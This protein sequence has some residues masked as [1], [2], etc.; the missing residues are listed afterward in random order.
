[1]THL[2][3]LILSLSLSPVYHHLTPY[4]S[5]TP[6][7]L[8]LPPISPITSIF[9]HH[10]IHSLQFQHPVLAEPTHNQIWTPVFPFIPNRHHLCP[11]ALA[12]YIRRRGQARS[13]S[14]LQ[15]SR[16]ATQQAL[17]LL[18]PR[19]DLPILKLQEWPLQPPPHQVL[20]PSWTLSYLVLRN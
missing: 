5:L 16:R 14:S 6:S 10:L 1:M 13:I 19:R 17:S 4:L 12:V 3:L 7:H 2:V 9:P 15:A 20:T 18:L 8:Y 11:Q